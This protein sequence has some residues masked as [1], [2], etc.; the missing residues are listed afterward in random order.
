MKEELENL[1]SENFTLKQTVVESNQKFEILQS[2]QEKDLAILNQK[3]DFMK[4][5]NQDITNQRD[6]EKRAFD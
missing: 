2:K 6:E 3:L 1:K 4:V 5:Q